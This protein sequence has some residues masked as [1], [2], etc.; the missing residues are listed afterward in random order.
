MPE[1]IHKPANW[2]HSFCVYP[3]QMQK[4][5]NQGDTQASM[6]PK[7]LRLFKSNDK[8]TS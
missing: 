2:E 6:G 3:Q 5:R 7:I 8:L 4:V 1:S